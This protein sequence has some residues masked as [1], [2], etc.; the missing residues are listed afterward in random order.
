MKLIP[1]AWDA[2]AFWKSPCDD[3]AAFGNKGAGGRE[4]FDFA[5]LLESNTLEF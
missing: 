2:F 1:A 4:K 5:S 3:W